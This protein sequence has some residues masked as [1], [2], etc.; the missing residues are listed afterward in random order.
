MR[1]ISGILIAGL[2]ASCL[3]P[4]HAQQKGGAKPAATKAAPAKPKEQAKPATAQKINWVSFQQA[5]ELNKTNPKKIFIDV[6]TDWCGWCKV[7]DKNTFTDPVI[8]EYMNKYF[9]AVKL[10]AEMK[11]T[12]VFNNIPFINP[13]PV[14]DPA[15]NIR[16]GTHQLAYSL[17][18][19]K[20]SYPTT[21]Y[22]DENFHML[23]PQPG[24]L[25]PP[26]MEPILVFYGQEKY[27]TI[28]WEEFTKTYQVR[29]TTPQQ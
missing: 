27:K 12:V 21:V 13:Q 5:V 2:I 10:D 6:Y 16:K 28:S 14:A 7:M 9:Y 18:N 8:I 4:V 11:D 26:Q 1:L 3:A 24:Y 17:L 29:S 20:L 15:N 23:S 19:G 25:T 22:L